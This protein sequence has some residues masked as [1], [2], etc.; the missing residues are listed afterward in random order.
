MSPFLNEK[1]LI[2]HAAHH[3]MGTVWLM[4]VLESVANKFGLKMTKSNSRRELAADDTDILFANHSQ[5]EPDSMENLVGSHMIRDLRDVV[6]SGYHYHLWTNESWA[7]EASD[8]FG[9]KSYQEMLQSEDKESGLA[10]EIRRLASTFDIRIL[11]KWDF[12]DARICELRYEDLWAD[13]TKEFHR[14]FQHYGFHEVAIS[15]CLNIVQQQSFKI[16][17][18]SV[19]ATQQQKMHLRSGMPGQWKSELTY[20]HCELVKA[21]LGDLIIKLGYAS[22]N[23]WQSEFQ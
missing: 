2:Y 13:E 6:V 14:L 5:F 21:E 12:S 15:K 8:Q 10:H 7:R 16:V 23:D 18:K 22:N 20:N 9:G 17:S 19:R 3:K 11:R 1:K 4:R